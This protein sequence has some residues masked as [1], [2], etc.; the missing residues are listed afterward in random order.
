M[1]EIV[2]EGIVNEGGLNFVEQEIRM[3]SRQAKT[4]ADSALVSR[5]NLTDICILAMPRLS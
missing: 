1:T 3:I 5:P 4:A 2:E